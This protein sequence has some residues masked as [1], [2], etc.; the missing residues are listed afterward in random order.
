M[1]LADLVANVRAQRTRPTQIVTV[2]VEVGGMPVTIVVGADEGRD[3][4]EC[5]LVDFSRF[6]I[7]DVRNEVRA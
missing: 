3:R 2:R 6:L 1:T 7:P 5:M 4:L